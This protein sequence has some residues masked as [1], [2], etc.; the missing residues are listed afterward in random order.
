MLNSQQPLFLK[1][2]FSQAPK[3]VPEMLV[4]KGGPEAVIYEM[5]FF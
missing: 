3:H 5:Y 4:R 1:T 2:P